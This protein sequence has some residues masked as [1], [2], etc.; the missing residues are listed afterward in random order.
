M[1]GGRLTRATVLIVLSMAPLT[2]G[3]DGRHQEASDAVS[4]GDPRLVVDR[5]VIDLG[6]VPVGR[7]AS[8]TFTLRNAGDAPLRFSD[9][10]WVKAV[11]GC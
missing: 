4:A 1:S 2:S 5:G 6:D 11:A 10:P 9:A 3:C 7:W 8:A